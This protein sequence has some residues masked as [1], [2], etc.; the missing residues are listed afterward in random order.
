MVRFLGLLLLTLGLTFGLAQSTAPSNEYKAA[1]T[2]LYAAAKT[3]SF[4]RD[5]C[6]TRA[7]N[8]TASVNAAYAAWYAAQGIAEIESRMAVLLGGNLAATNST[9]EESRNDAYTS[10]DANVSDPNQFCGN[11]TAFLQSSFDLRRQFASDYRQMASQL[12]SNQTAPNSA[13]RKPQGSNSPSTPASSNPQPSS[14]AGTQPSSSPSVPP[15]DPIKLLAAGFDAKKE[16]TPDEYRCY[17]KRKSDQYTRPD[18]ILQILSKRQYRFLGSTGAFQVDGSDVVFTS[19]ALSSKREHYFIFNRQFGTQIWLYDVGTDETDYRCHQRGAAENLALLEFKRK[20]PGVGKYTCIERN[21]PKAALTQLEVLP[22]RQYRYAG[23][24][25]R[26]EV[27][28]LGDQ[29][30]YYSTVDFVGGVWDDERAFYEEDEY[31]QQSWRVNASPRLECLRQGTPRPNPKFGSK[32]APKPPAGSGGISGRYYSWSVDIPIGGMYFCGG[33]CYEYVFFDKNGYVFTGDP[34]DTEGTPDSDCSKTYPSG[35]PICDVY[36]ISGGKITIGR[37]KA[38]T[39]KPSKQGLVMDGDDYTPL[40][41]LGN[42]K[43]QG[44][45]NSFTASGST[46]GAPSSFTSN[47]DFM[48]SSN[49]KFTRDA[50]NTVFAS[51]TSDGT[52]FGS[53][54]A[55]VSSWSQRQNSGTYSIYDNTLELKFLD[56]RVVKKFIFRVD[57]DFYRIGGRNYTK[58]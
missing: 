18:Q 1:V 52:A 37:Q 17:A 43:L 40:L 29:S 55:S 8:T 50:S 58:K 33:L 35:Y 25:G 13:Q 30:D 32:A 7:P 42:L 48:F 26:L 28:I 31:G 47:V 14:S 56:G 16:P 21:N 6:L 15:A 46:F 20:D 2:K 24:V 53:T 9:L 3:A 27:N 49:G 34:E 5:W 19:G 4:L 38:V 45:Y 12:L 54:T 57:K 11:L 36:K 22:N 23:Q 10:F 41:P 39:F 44:T 51:A